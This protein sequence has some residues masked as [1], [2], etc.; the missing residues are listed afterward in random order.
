MHRDILSASEKTGIPVE[1]YHTKGKNDAERYV[2]EVLTQRESLEQILSPEEKSAHTFRFYACGG[3]GSLN[4]VINGV[5]GQ[6]YVEVACIPLGTG[7]DFI[8]NFTEKNDLKSWGNI[9]KQLLGKAKD[10]D[11]I[12][13]SGII[14]GKTDTRYC[15]NMFNIGFDSNVVDMTEK[16]KDLPL[17]PGPLA[18]MISVFIVLIKKKGADLEVLF[19]DGNGYNGKLLLLAIGNG[20]F[21]GGGIKGLAKADINDGLLDNI[22]V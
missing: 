1:I 4:E 14:D 20:C 2:R 5:A 3:D 7:N 16:I 22:L 15:A 17:M 9:E 13:Y 21:C 12:R 10:C 19:E 6:P 18:Y 8:K 11:L